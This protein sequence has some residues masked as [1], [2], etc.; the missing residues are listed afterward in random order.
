LKKSID[1][2]SC[3]SPD[4]SPLIISCCQLFSQ[5]TIYVANLFW[6]LKQKKT[7]I[8]ILSNIPIS[9]AEAQERR[10]GGGYI[11]ICGYVATVK[12]EIF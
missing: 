4:P 6:R 3:H 5:L 10:G 11:K 1:Y 2:H 12:N 8:K 7:K 9:T